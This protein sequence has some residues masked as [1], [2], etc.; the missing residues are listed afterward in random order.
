MRLLGNSTGKLVLAGAMFAS[1]VGLG[2]SARV[3][4]YDVDHRDYHYWNG[5]EVVVYRS[6]WGSRNEPYREYSSLNPEEQR[7]YWNWRHEHQ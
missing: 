5:H 1:I 2:C 7:A 4:Y 6:Y 3:R